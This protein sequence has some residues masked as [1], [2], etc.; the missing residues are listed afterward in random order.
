MSIY[1]EKHR[2]HYLNLHL[3]TPKNK[4]IDLEYFSRTG[5]S[6]TSYGV[7][8]RTKTTDVYIDRMILCGCKS[9]IQKMI[10]LFK[11]NEKNQTTTKIDNRKLENTNYANNDEIE[12]NSNTQLSSPNKP[13]KFDIA[14][15]FDLS[16]QNNLKVETLSKP[17][18]KKEKTPHISNF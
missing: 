5:F 15:D 11:K 12:K 3:F 17:F 16:G 8:G 2:P 18:E 13:L 7:C 10:Y 14:E 6:I 1:N 9:L 4:K